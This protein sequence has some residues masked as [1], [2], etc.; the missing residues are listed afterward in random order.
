MF[1]PNDKTVN[2]TFT[3]DTLRFLFAVN[4]YRRSM[5]LYALRLEAEMAAYLRSLNE[6]DRKRTMQSLHLDLLF[7]CIHIWLP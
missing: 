2:R 3:L 6:R 4:A 5:T 1:E 7:R